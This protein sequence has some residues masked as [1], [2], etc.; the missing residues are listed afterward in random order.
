MQKLIA[1]LVVI[2]MLLGSFTQS[3]YAEDAS[4]EH[5]KKVRFIAIYDDKCQWSCGVVKPLVEGLKKDYGEKVEF[6]ELNTSKGKI[7]DSTK[8]AK[9]LGV[10]SFFT[11]SMAYIPCVGVFTKSGKLVKEIPA[12]K[13][14]EM[15]VKFIDKALA[16]KN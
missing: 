4:K 14:K 11:S 6:Y 9:E 1:Y 10:E 8:L 12:A 5:D 13:P 15:Y 16:A 3:S 7:S 2:A